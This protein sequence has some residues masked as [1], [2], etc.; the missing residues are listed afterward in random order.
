MKKIKI[1]LCDVRHKTMGLH[2][3]QMP[4]G[5]GMIASY[6]NKI[7]GDKVEIRLYKYYDK[8]REVV[9]CSF[10]SWNRRLTLH[11]IKQA[12]K[13]NPEVYTIIGGPELELENHKREEFLL[14]NPDIDICCMGAGEV[15]SVEIFQLLLSD[16]N[17]RLENKVDGTFFLH[18]ADNRLVVNPL[19]KN[20]VSLD[21]VPSPYTSGLFDQFFADYLHPFIE[22]HRGCPFECRF[23]HLG[24]EQ[25]NKVTFQSVKRTLED[26]EY[27]AQRYADRS[28]IQL[29]IADNNFAMYKKD[30]EL[31]HGIRSLQDKY[32]WPRYMVTSTGKNMKE[33]IVKVSNILKWGLP[34]NMAAQSMHQETLDIIGR[35]NISLESMKQTLL[36]VKNSDADSYTEVIACLPGE[37]KE[38]FEN[39][40]REAIG[41][42]LNWISILTLRLLNGTWLTYENTIEKYKF[43]IRYRVITRQIG[44]YDNNRIIEIEAAVV[45]T[46]TTSFEDY[47]DLRE[48]SYIIQVIYNSDTF[49]SIRR[50]LREYNVEVWSWLKLVHKLTK[51]NKGKPKEQ[52]NGFMEETAG[53]MFDS[54]QELIDYFS[55]DSN[56]EKLLT[57]EIGDNLMAK[58]A[59][60]AATDAFD[61]WL[62]LSSNAAKQLLIS[63]LPQQ[64]VDLIIGSLILYINNQYNFATYFFEPPKADKSE[65]VVFDFDVP[66]WLKNE[67]LL[68]NDLTGGVSYESFFTEDKVNKINFLL[69]SSHDM[70]FTIQRVYR[71]KNYDELIP[72]LRFIVPVR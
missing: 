22:T 19:R 59:V 43:D 15:T 44:G 38:T 53:E 41:T 31:A 3:Y 50:V 66:K 12:R 17:P 62:E 29:C 51:E 30:I 72:E 46:N 34:F 55:H 37:T 35:S 47:C 7:L 67:N 57:G 68:I 26:L 6:A 48:L 61:E 58:Y 16:H 63:C 20:L 27:C 70:S 18:P 69:E 42:N 54:E 64:K 23:C 60:L 28:D 8:L 65:Q 45:G 14:D 40:L 71:D 13:L 2:G 21:D 9:G 36:E 25:H 4:L 24:L 56:Y 39:G 52:L 11:V 32:N 5:I 1:A 10:F 33:R 49:N